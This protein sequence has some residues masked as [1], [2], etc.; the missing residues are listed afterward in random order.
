MFAKMWM[1]DTLRKEAS[2]QEVWIHLG[3]LICNEKSSNTFLY[4]VYVKQIQRCVFVKLAKSNTYQVEVCPHKALPN[5]YNRKHN[6]QF[7][8]GCLEGKTFVLLTQANKEQIIFLQELNLLFPYFLCSLLVLWIRSV[9][10]S[11]LNVMR[12]G[13][14]TR[15]HLVI[16]TPTT[17][18]LPPPCTG[19]SE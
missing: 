12:L 6:V 3:I 10:H 18:Q 19:L 13:K 5:A 14:T 4:T 1:S 15:H 7:R 8:Q 16:T 2:T 11:T 9:Q 17:P